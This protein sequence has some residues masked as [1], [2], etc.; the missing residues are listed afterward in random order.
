MSI[1]VH[2]SAVVESEAELGEGVV[3]E[4]FCYVGSEVKLGAD[5]HLRHH[6]TVEGNVVMGEG[7]EVFPY[8]LIGGKTHDLKYE[9]GSPGLRIGDRNV[10][11]EY[12]TTHPATKEG[13]ATIIGS[14]NVLLAY[15]HVAHDCRVGDHL[16]M[17]SHS[18]LGGHVEVGDY[19]NV[20]WGVGVHQFCRLGSHCMVSACSKVVQ[21]VPPFVLADGSPAEGRSINKIGMERAGFSADAIAVARM[22]FK[23][24]Y[25][26]G[27]NRTQA[28]EEFAS[29]PEAEHPVAQEMIDFLES[30]G[31]GLA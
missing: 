18:A 4:A 24:L 5:C 1:K 10:F 14:S 21:D 28:L 9:G 25:K 30:S 16:V 12:V 22:L 26:E 23:L 13:D 3:V 19:A 20:G 6:S 29:R 27:L 15:S 17:S 8:S 7:N 11:R 31:R 2:S